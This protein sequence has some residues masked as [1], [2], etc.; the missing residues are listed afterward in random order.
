[1]VSRSLTAD[2]KEKLN[3]RSLL[4]TGPEGSIQPTAGGRIGSQGRVQTEE[5]TEP[6]APVF[7]MV[8]GWSDLGFLGE[9]QTRQFKEQSFSKCHRHFTSGVNRD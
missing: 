6:G 1:M 5:A 4:P 9:G 3:S 2:H 7:V 8:R